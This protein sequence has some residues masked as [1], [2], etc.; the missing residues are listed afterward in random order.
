MKAWIEKH[1]KLLELGGAILTGLFA[2]L[3]TGC[4]TGNPALDR[5]AIRGQA[6]LWGMR[7]FGATLRREHVRA[8]LAIV[9]NE[10]QGLASNYLG[11]TGIASGPSIGPMQV[12][13][14][15]VLSS[16]PTDPVLAVLL[17][18]AASD[19]NAYGALAGNE[20]LGMGLGVMVFHQ[21]YLAAGGDLQGAIDLY[22][23]DGGPGNPG[24]YSQK[25]LA[26][27]QQTWSDG[28]S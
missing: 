4:A 8:I 10:S 5:F 25:A 22:N 13:R 3:W 21:K 27:A 26:F 23:G 14:Q 1:R 9:N 2:L 15:T 17:G 28:L 12:L 20:I 11:D 16:A 24:Q 19:Q 18:G 7:F 6:I